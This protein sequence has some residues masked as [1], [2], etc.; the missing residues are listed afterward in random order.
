M[1]LTAGLFAFTI[2]ILVA[3]LT[4]LIVVGAWHR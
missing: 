4:Y 2:L 1:R 3:G